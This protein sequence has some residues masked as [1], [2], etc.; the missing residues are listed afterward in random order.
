MERGRRTAEGPVVELLQRGL[1]KGALPL[2]ARRSTTVTSL[3]G[4]YVHLGMERAAARDLLKRRFNR[5]L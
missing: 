2:V 1:L 3:P 5:G 4:T